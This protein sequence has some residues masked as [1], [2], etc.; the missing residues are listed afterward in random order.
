MDPAHKRILR[1][2]R[3]DI[4]NDLNVNRVKENLIQEEIFDPSQWEDIVTA[5]KGTRRDKASA[6]MD[7]L[8]KRGP[9]AF[10]CFCDSLMTGRYEHLAKPLIEEEGTSFSDPYEKAPLHVTELTKQ[11]VNDSDIRKFGSVLVLIPLLCDL[12]ERAVE[13]TRLRS[14]PTSKVAEKPPTPPSPQEPS[15]TK[16]E[17]QPAARDPTST[18]ILDAVTNLGLQMSKEMAEMKMKLDEQAQLLKQ[19]EDIK[20][21]LTAVFNRIKNME[22]TFGRRKEEATKFEDR[23]KKLKE[24]VANLLAQDINVTTLMEETKG[25][26][27]EIELIMKQPQDGEVNINESLKEMNDKVHEVQVILLKLT[28]LGFSDDEISK[29]RCFAP[30][31]L[32]PQISELFRLWR[33]KNGINATLEALEQACRSSGHSRLAGMISSSGTPRADTGTSR[34]LLDK[35]ARPTTQEVNLGGG[36]GH[37]ATGARQTSSTKVRGRPAGFNLPPAHCFRDLSPPHSPEGGCFQ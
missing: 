25:I 20:G 16:P 6:L 35:R 17:D 19:T 13:V 31:Y 32:V 18:A 15:A 7:E 3:V 5:G 8:P 37:P 2:H 24:R 4:V 33:E 9:M 10:Q 11:G 36:R 23:I 30:G 27:S 1:S 28:G 12:A 21:R 14:L 22:E 34:K 29:I 26:Q